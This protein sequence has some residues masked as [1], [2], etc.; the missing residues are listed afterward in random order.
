MNAYFKS[1]MIY[2][3]IHLREKK[4]LQSFKVA[5]AAVLNEWMFLPGHKLA[6]VDTTGHH[7]HQPLL[8][9]SVLVNAVDIRAAFKNWD[10]QD[11]ELAE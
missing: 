3:S 5:P 2:S 7:H 11:K 9:F 8:L 1:N 10:K 4:M 6:C